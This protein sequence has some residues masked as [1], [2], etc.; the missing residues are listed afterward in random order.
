MTTKVTIE[1]TPDSATPD[2]L[3]ARIAEI[4]ADFVTQAFSTPQ[5]DPNSQP[6]PEIHEP[7]SIREE[8]DRM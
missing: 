4:C 3:E 8:M 2:E 6:V 1:I 5:R 7:I